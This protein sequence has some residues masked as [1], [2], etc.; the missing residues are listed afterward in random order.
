MRRRQSGQAIAIVAL[1]I[2]ILVGMAGIAIDGARAYA[3]RRDLQAAT[4]AAALAASD[5]LQ[6]SGSYVSAEQAA[7]STFG[8][9]LRL[10]AAPSCSPGYGSPGASPFTVTCTYGDGTTLTQSASALGP[11]G[12]QFTITARRS[13]QLQFARVLTNG[14]IPTL[15]ATAVGNVNNLA[16]APTVAAL[17]GSGCGGTSGNALTVNGSGTLDVTGDVVSNGAIS[18]AAGTLRVAG[19]LQA[20]CQS[21]VAGAVNACY[22]SGGSTPCSY[23]DVAGATRSGFRLADPGYPPP[24]VGGSASISGSNVLV[25]AGVYG[26]TPILAGGGCWFLTGGVYDFQVGVINFGDFVSNE[27]KPPDEPD[28]SNNTVRSANQFWNTNGVRCAGAA[29]LSLVTGMHAVATGNWALVIT[30]ERSDTYAGVSYLRESA[31]SMCYATTVSTNDKNLQIAVSNVPG[32]TSYNI[33]VSPP[34]AGGTCAGP[35]GLVANLPV[36]VTVQN[37]QLGGC[38]AVTGTGCS[39]GNQSIRLDATQLG[40]PFAPNAAAAPGTTGSYPPDGETSPVAAGLPNQNPARGNG[41]SGDRANENEC[42][43]T[44]GGASSCPAAVTPGA[45]ALYFPNGAC[46]GT[47]NSSD[48]YLFSGYQYDW[49]IG[50]EPTGNTCANFIGGHG[51]SAFIGLFYAP[52][53]TMTVASQYVAESPATGGMMLGSITFSGTLP[54]ITLSADYAPVP[55]AGRLSG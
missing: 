38:P 33:Y 40:P 1:M 16:Y 34:S 26:S 54:S 25:Q 48:T 5:K 51:N 53:A 29:Q 41:V 31:P 14:A 8:T 36:T 42:R 15:G 17:R 9:N 50:Y 45:V 49:L 55:P 7:T 21:S 43:A 27:L 44:N 35:F 24:P 30:S 46:V 22:A 10:Y 52:D 6:Q 18:V 37:N 19:D 28:P 12:S 20:R 23:P 3:L 47:S 2:T 11:R 13:L 4:D 39:L 32:A